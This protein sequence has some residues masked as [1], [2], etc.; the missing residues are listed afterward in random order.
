MYKI[1]CPLAPC[2]AKIY[3][4]KRAQIAIDN[5]NIIA[6]D[7]IALSRRGSSPT[8]KE[9]S[10]DHPLSFGRWVKVLR[11]ALT[12]TGQT[13]RAQESPLNLRARG[14]SETALHLRRLQSTLSNLSSDAGQHLITWL[15]PPDQYSTHNYRDLLKWWRLTRHR[16]RRI[17]RTLALH[18]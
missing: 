17:Y 1:T 5:A 3:D 11:V 18:R 4:R 7:I 9:W 14:D 12:Y 13:G 16:E 6:C 15:T 10:I 2:G 8:A